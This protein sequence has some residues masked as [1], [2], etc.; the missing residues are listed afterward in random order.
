[1]PSGG[2]GRKPKGG[3]P[4]GERVQ[5]PKSMVG[6]YERAGRCSERET[7]ERDR[8]GGAV[9]GGRQKDDWEEPLSLTYPGIFLQPLFWVPESD[10]GQL[11]EKSSC[12]SAF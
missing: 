12:S 6:R 7:R 11:T 1:M 5:G 8:G 3:K 10:D 9:V 2:R 4:E